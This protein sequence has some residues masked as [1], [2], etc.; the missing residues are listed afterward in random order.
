VLLGNIHR[1]E[2][3]RAG[4]LENARGDLRGERA[5]PLD[6]VLKRLQLGRDERADGTDEHTLLLVER[7][8]HGQSRSG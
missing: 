1:I 7:E 6:L 5:G 4:L 3:E 2:A 8:I